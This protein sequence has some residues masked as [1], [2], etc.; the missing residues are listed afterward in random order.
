M[1]NEKEIEPE[2]ILSLN[3]SGKVVI[4][5]PNL[6]IQFSMENLR[7][8]VRFGN[9]LK[10]LELIKKEFENA[11]QDEVNERLKPYGITVDDILYSEELMD[12]IE[13]VYHEDRKID[14]NDD[15]ALQNTLFVLETWP[16]D[17]IYRSKIT[18]ASHSIE[19]TKTVYGATIEDI[20]KKCK[21]TILEL[22]K[23]LH[24]PEICCL[25]MIDTKYDTLL[26]Q[27]CQSSD[28]PL[29]IDQKTK[30]IQCSESFCE[31]VMR[32]QR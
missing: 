6:Q 22:H 12:K 31:K 4:D 10:N 25:T 3:D 19:I 18:L 30:D 26:D 21:K 1:K 24:E 11:Y 15:Q 29:I 17:E 8:I 9:K 16:K 27:T 7:K 20:N 23:D 13:E 5:Q 28:V 32:G 14:I 2:L